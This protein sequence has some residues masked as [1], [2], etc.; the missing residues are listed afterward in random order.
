MFK[1]YQD[2]YPYID[3]PDISDGEKLRNIQKAFRK[4][5]RD[6]EIFKEE[7]TL[8]LEAGETDYYI[9]P[10]SDSS[11][12][13]VVSVTANGVEQSAAEF[14]LAADQS[15][16]VFETAPIESVTDGLVVEIIILPDFDAEKQDESIMNTWAEAIISLTKYMIY[17]QSNK[18]YYNPN[19]EMVALGE[20]QEYYQMITHESVNSYISRSNVITV[21]NQSQG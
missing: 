10:L 8:D 15:T 7:I 6:T 14:S 11:I 3:V 16:L 9:V 18:S 5:A 17:K 21:P 4:F 20:Y 12:L 19:E 2:F 1:T 13:R